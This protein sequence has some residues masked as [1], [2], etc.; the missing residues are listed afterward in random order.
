MAIF[1]NRM[2]RAA[3][4]CR[5]RA[6]STNC[7]HADRHGAKTAS[8]A[9]QAWVGSS[10]R[11]EYNHIGYWPDNHSRLTNSYNL[12]RGWGIE[13]QE[14]DWSVI[15][16]HIFEVLAAGDQDKADYVLDWC[17]HLIQRPWE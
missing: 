7:L 3:L 16:E 14:G 15:R 9:A 1:T 11:C 10:G 5:D 4:S 13:P 17:A 8:T 6:V 2:T 12:W